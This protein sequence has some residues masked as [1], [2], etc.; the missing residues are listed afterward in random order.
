[1]YGIPQIVVADNMPFIHMNLRI[2]QI[3]GTSKLKP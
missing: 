3:S 2:L 1:M